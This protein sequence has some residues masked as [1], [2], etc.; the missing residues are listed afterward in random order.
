MSS[1][2]FS[3]GMFR[4]VSVWRL[5]LDWLRRGEMWSRL[6]RRLS[7]VVFGWVL[8]CQVTAVKFG[9]VLVGYDM[10]SHGN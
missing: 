9:R 3:Y 7:L 4:F 5:S 10:S 2:E 6:L 8:I 1:V